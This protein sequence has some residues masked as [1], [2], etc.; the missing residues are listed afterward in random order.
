MKSIEWGLLFNEYHMNDYD[1][2]E[3]ENIVEDLMIDDD[4]NNKKGIY[5]YLFN[6]K[7]K[8]LSIRA[9][10]PAMKRAA[11]E[12]QNGICSL[13]GNEFKI[14]EMEAGARTYVPAPFIYSI[15]DSVSH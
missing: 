9:F 3:L 14:N 5:Y 6:Q 4:V 15:S 13:C 1:A 12:R 2:E 8:H 7:E 10:S 11:F